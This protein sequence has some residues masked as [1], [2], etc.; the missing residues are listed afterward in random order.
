MDTSILQNIDDMSSPYAKQLKEGF[1]RLRFM[2]DLEVEFQEQYIDQLLTRIRP[3]LW[4]GIVAFAAFGLWDLLSLPTE[5]T[6]WTIPIRFFVIYPVFFL[7]WF[8][9]SRASYRR[10]LNAFVFSSVLVAGLGIVA[11]VF[12][13]RVYQAPLPWEGVLLL[14]MAAY[15]LTGL[16]F[17]RAFFCSL[18]V[19]FA[20]VL[21]ELVAGY[22]PAILVSNAIFLIFANI[23]GMCGSYTL[24]RNIRINYLKTKLL[25]ELADRDGLT[26][27]YNRRMFNV[28]LERIWAQALREKK[29]LA[30]ALVDVDYFK[31]FNDFY[32]HLLGDECLKKVAKALRLVARR[33]LDFAARY[34]G[35]EFVLVRYHPTLESVHEFAEDILRAV[36]ALQ[37]KH[38]SSSVASYVT[39]SVGLTFVFPTEEQTL[40]QFVQTAD[41]ALYQAKSQGRNQFVFRKFSSE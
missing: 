14:T 18:L 16:L 30:L 2:D 4:I 27:I 34:G 24:E 32:G 15:L 35:E 36:S 28:Y 3:S 5:V 22:T 13:A 17:Y 38:E 40:E 19:F 8:V 33:P 23:I 29:S 31:P 9:S 25:E 41:E 1:Q 6:R 26:G 7:T 20:Y 10:Y 37:I 21:S 39:V 12:V 11:I